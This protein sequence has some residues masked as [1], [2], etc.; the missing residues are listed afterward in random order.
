MSQEAFAIELKNLIRDPPID[1]FVAWAGIPLRLSRD[2][3]SAQ[4]E[5]LLI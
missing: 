3:I 5:K 2:D 4:D 1:V